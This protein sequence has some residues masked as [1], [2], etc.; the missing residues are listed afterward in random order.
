[1]HMDTRKWEPERWRCVKFP[2]LPGMNAVAPQRGVGS[3]PYQKCIGINGGYCPLW[4]ER[5]GNEKD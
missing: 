4:T 3:P 5:Q 1:M 2:R